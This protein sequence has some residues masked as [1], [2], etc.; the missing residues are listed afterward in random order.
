[1]MQSRLACYTL[2][3]LKS[4]EHHKQQRKMLNPAFS[5]THLKQMTPMFYRVVHTVGS[6]LEKAIL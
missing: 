6:P 2:I 5:V 1:M 4:G 3:R